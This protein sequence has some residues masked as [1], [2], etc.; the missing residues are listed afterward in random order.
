MPFTKIIKPMLA[1]D[2]PNAFDSPDYLFEIKWDGYRCLAYCGDDVKLFSR[3]HRNLNQNF[4]EIASDLEQISCR[5]I[6]DGELIMLGEDQ[7]PSFSRLQ[8]KSLGEIATYIVFDIL[9]LNDQYLFE[10]PLIKRREL[11]RSL[12]ENSDLNHVVISRAIEKHGKNF[13]QAAVNHELEGI[14]AK[15]KTSVYLPGKRSSAWLKIKHRPETDAVIVGYLPGRTGFKSLLLGQYGHGRLVFIGAV[16]TG[17]S[18]KEKAVLTA[19]LAK[20]VSDCALVDKP[21]IANV[22]WVKPILV[23]K[24]GYLEYTADGRLRQPSFLGLRTDKKAEECVM[25]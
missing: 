18:E 4:K 23:A 2:H 19:G 8:R 25:P 12:I 20:I 11:L 9:Y 21:E 10:Q 5:C 22:V 14:V 3:S 17:F 16:G 1:V 7:K 15:E 13:F 6:L 24:V